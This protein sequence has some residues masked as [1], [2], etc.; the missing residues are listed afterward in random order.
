MLRPLAKREDQADRDRE[1]Q[2]AIAQL[3]G[4]AESAENASQIA[5]ALYRRSSGA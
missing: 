3:F 4:V 1:H 5:L 2:Q